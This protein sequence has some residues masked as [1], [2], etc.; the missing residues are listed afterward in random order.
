MDDYIRAVK[1]RVVE[2]VKASMLRWF[3]HV[4][5][6]KHEQLVKMYGSEVM[7]RDKRHRT[8]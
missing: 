2:W 8:L 1:C 4:K 5:R 3:G 7:G 6:M